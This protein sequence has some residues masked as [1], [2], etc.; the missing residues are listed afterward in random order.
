MRVLISGVAG[1]IGSHLADLVLSQGYDVVG[2]DN[3]ITGDRRN[4]AHLKDKGRF[5]L[6]EHDV[7]EPMRVDGAV[8]QIYH[9]ASP[10]SPVA[11][12]TQRVA[13]LKVNGVGTCNLLDVAVQKQA[14]FLVASTAEVYGD[15]EVT[16]Q[17]EDYWG[18]VNPIGLNSVYEESKRYAE[19]CAM[20]YQRQHGVDT[21]TARIFNTYGPRMSVND[22]RVITNFVCQAL[23][24]EPIT[25]YGD[26][27]QTRCFCYVS[28]MVVGILKAMESDFH[29]PINLGNPDEVSMVQLA[30]DILQLVGSAS[31][32][33]F[34][35]APAYDP[36]IRKPD[37]ARA[38]QILGW[39]PKVPRMEG[40]VKVV[41]YY[42]G[43]G[44]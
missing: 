22:G 12:M 5:Q 4:I 37:V 29:E 9:L 39:S 18:R 2:V 33:C 17:R 6:I 20:A 35:P 40:L 30:R 21:R 10:S 34:E 26:G 1:F 42:R 44:Q 16:P 11:Y 27:T 31:K 36:R 32:I 25:V 3:F 13:T 24:G 15:P 8:D 43:R 19:A 14:R 38:R 28:D 23:K 41:E 7:I